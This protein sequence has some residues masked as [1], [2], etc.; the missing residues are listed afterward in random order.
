M[1]S[2]ASPGRIVVLLLASGALLATGCAVRRDLLCQVP[3]P[4]PSQNDIFVKYLGVGG[5]LL[6]RGQQ[7]LMTPPLLSNPG[8]L[9]VGLGRVRSDPR[10]V[11]AGLRRVGVSDED[12]K[13]V[14]AILVGHAH[15]DH[16]LD[17]P[18]LW[19]KASKAKIYGSRTVGHLLAAE[20]SGVPRDAFCNVSGRARRYEDDVEDSD[21]IEVVPGDDKLGAVRILPLIAEHAP[22]FMGVQAW[23]GGLREDVK[24][25]PR[26]AD[27]WPQGLTL[28][29]LID[30]LDI[31]G[32][33]AF[34]IHFSDSSLAPPCGYVPRRLGGTRGVNLALLTTGGSK[35]T[36]L[37]PEELLS[38]ACVE[39]VLLGHWEW[40][41][42]KYEGRGSLDALPDVEPLLW[43][44]R[45]A[46]LKQGCFPVPGTVFAF[47]PK[48]PPPCPTL[49]EYPPR[50]C[51]CRPPL[52]G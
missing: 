36:G 1:E 40:F 8:P 31:N 25:L 32:G 5:F 42:R 34:R 41:F 7:A 6:T 37:Y 18:E 19:R 3:Q 23:P 26:T 17:V 13:R 12:L 24:S 2:T 49:A 11:R 44:V 43:K 39:Q 30:F 4:P 20:D 10:Q 16:L 50:H 38:N 33:V 15:Y 14:Q 21:W 52:P 47:A 48:P 29:Y 35:D 9:A 51:G 46:R 28:A 22:Q 45:A 27:R